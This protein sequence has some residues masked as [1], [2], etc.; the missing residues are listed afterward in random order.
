MFLRG[1]EIFLRGRGLDKKAQYAKITSKII[2]II[3]KES[4]MSKGDYVPHSDAKLADWADNFVERLEA[5][6]LLW[7]VAAEETAEIKSAAAD[8]RALHSKTS[9]KG[10]RTQTL[11]QQKNTARERLTALIRALA[12]FRLKNPIITDAERLALGL[13]VRDKAYTRIDAPTAQPTVK[14][15]ISRNHYEHKLK[16]LN[17][18]GDSSK[19]SDAQVVHYAWQVGG[20]PPQTGAELKNS[21]FSRCTR[22]VV[23]YTEAEEG[24]IVYYSCCYEN[25]KGDQGPWA[26]T[27]RAIIA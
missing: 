25:S 2:P 19:P 22:Y 7:G 10:A 4:I 21:R 8:F 13:H 1:P 16:V 24:K 27:A 14:I 23:K 17:P 12:G 18:S 9:N 3:H 20:E 6:G 26:A 11:T 5:N 15:L